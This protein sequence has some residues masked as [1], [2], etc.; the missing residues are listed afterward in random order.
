MARR[1]NRKRGH[2]Y[3][4]DGEMQ[5]KNNPSGN[6]LPNQIMATVDAVGTMAGSWAD[7]LSPN[8]NVFKNNLEQ[9]DDYIDNYSNQNYVINS[10]ADMSFKPIDLD[11]FET[12]G[13]DDNPLRKSTG[14]HLSNLFSQIGAG[15]AAGSAIGPWGTIAGAIVGGLS[16]AGSWI[17]GDTKAEKERLAYNN[18]IS[19]MKALALE[20]QRQNFLNYADAARDY[21]MRE[22]ISRGK[23]VVAAKG[24]KISNMANGLTYFGE[25][26][27]HE[28][29][30]YGGIQQGIAPDGQPNLV[31]EGEVK[32]DQ[33]SNKLNV[34]D[35]NG[36]F[37]GQDQQDGGYIFSNRTMMPNGKD[38]VAEHVVKIQKEAA[39]R[40]F[41]TISQDTLHDKLNE[42]YE[43]Q[44]NK[45]LE[46]Q[47][48]NMK[49]F[50]KGGHMFSGE[51]DNASYLHG[52]PI[53]RNNQ[54]L[55]IDP[56]SLF[57]NPIKKRFQATPFSYNDY[58]NPT[59]KMSQYP[60]LENNGVPYD[61]SQAGVQSVWNDN[62]QWVSPDYT[63]GPISTYNNMSNRNAEISALLADQNS[64][65]TLKARAARAQQA[66]IKKAISNGIAAN[67]PLASEWPDYVTNPFASLPKSRVGTKSAFWDNVISNIGDPSAYVTPEQVELQKDVLKEEQEIQA[68]KQQEESQRRGRGISDILSRIN[69]NG[70]LEYLR[71]A[72]VLGS[73]IDF[74]QHR[75]DKPDFSSLRDL[76]AAIKES[77]GNQVKA[78]IVGNY[79]SY[80]PAPITLAMNQLASNAM[81]QE[82]NN[83]N[84][85]ANPYAAAHANDIVRY[86]TNNAYG[87]A[88]LDDYARN[89]EFLNN[90]LKI[91]DSIHQANRDAALRADMTNAQQRDRTA[92]LAAH[93][94]NMKYNI[95]QDF[96]NRQL[97]Y[98]TNFWQ[99]L[100]NVG[101]DAVNRNQARWL[102][103]NGVPEGIKDSMING[104]HLYSPYRRNGNRN[105]GRIKTRNKR[106]LT[107]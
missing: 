105:G 102:I 64:E 26:G 73:A 19:K 56:G 53:E 88:L 39:E 96:N 95:M 18:E 43:Y 75:N 49:K 25:G 31:E 99:N 68:L 86:N 80:R 9:Y 5:I 66:R 76:E 97:N 106:G 38:T 21:D 34:A 54:T 93:F 15:A 7:A 90:V 23:N 77:K 85:M 81:A 32:W 50:A 28:Q 22:F 87:Q 27:T 17:A 55:E 40:P 12:I 104:Y 33:D 84:T 67:D 14:S 103:E 82:A 101:I 100:G 98:R 48:N 61:W 41:D 30:P 69:G 71:F 24:G 78:N 3:A 45:R 8:K 37:G 20:A 51:Y 46:E 59:N 91:N 65:R 92:N 4:V 94:A 62:P 52:Y 58:V 35:K 44:E 10:P 13:Y 107:Y 63:V 60:V 83:I 6:M 2:I 89:Q 42:A 79:A 16:G 11:Q 74:F 70:L 47:M 29:N 57:W 36:L 1:Y 72:P